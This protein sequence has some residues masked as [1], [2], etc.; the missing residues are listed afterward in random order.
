MWYVAALAEREGAVLALG[1]GG[2]VAQLAWAMGLTGS[3]CHQDA[4]HNKSPRNPGHERLSLVGR[5]E[6][7]GCWWVVGG[8][9][10]WR[11]ARLRACINGRG[12]TLS[13]SPS[14]YRRLL[15]GWPQPEIGRCQSLQG[16]H[17]P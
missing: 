8:S 10:G 11:E 1:T 13:T 15:A 9:D 3:K 7:V 2:G 17:Q 5:P 16:E 4:Q 12:G 14:D 6:G